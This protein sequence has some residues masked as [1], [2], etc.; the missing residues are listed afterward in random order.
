MV[1][2]S[3]K[4]GPGNA[5]LGQTPTADWIGKITDETVKADMARGLVGR[6]RSGDVAYLVMRATVAALLAEFL[7]AFA[8]AAPIVG[9]VIL[10]VQLIALD[11]ECARAISP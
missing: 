2:P 6:N 11:A 3:Q 10:F 9:A 5:R 4:I 7:L 8:I 1:R